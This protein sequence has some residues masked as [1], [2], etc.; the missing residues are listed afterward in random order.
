MLHIAN[1]SSFVAFSFAHSQL[2]TELSMKLHENK[3]IMLKRSLK[4]LK[5]KICFILFEI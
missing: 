5:F 3:K 1:P 2:C 4:N